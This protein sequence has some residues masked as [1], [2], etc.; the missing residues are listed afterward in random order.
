[1][2]CVNDNCTTEYK[3]QPWDAPESI[4][5]SMDGDMACCSECRVEYEEQKAH[6]LD[7]IM[8]NEEL[9]LD[10]LAPQFRLG[11]LCKRNG[12]KT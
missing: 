3:K 5:V 7:N 6:F 8:P 10:W 11:S 1:M 4:V 9:F 12:V 2:S